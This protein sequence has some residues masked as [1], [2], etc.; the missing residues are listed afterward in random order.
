MRVLLLAPFPPRCDATHGGARVLGQ[1]ISHL[2][3]R[4]QVAVIYLRENGEPGIDPDVKARCDRVWE[5]ALPVHPTRGI[6]HWARR[7]SVL[8]GLLRGY[9]EWAL[10]WRVT[11]FQEQLQIA[12]QTWNPDVIQVEYSVM[13]QYLQGLDG[14]GIPSILTIYEPVAHAAAE[15]ALRPRHLAIQLLLLQ[16]AW[17]RYERRIIAAASAVVTF[18]DRD[19]KLIEKLAPDARVACIPLG[20]DLT[21]QPLDPLGTTPTSIT[22]IGNFSHPPNVD[23]AE[24]LIQSIFPAVQ[25]QVPDAILCIVGDRVPNNIRQMATRSIVVTGWVPSVIPYLDHAAV[26]AAPIR[27]GG[28]MRVKMLEALIA[29]K[30]I[31]ASPRA[32]E[33]IGV[34]A[35][36]HLLL[37]HDDRQFADAITCLLRNDPLR[38]ELAHNARAWALSHLGWSQAMT[39]YEVLY[40]SL[41]QGIP[42]GEAIMAG[43][44]HSEPGIQA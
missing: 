6:S 15:R 27:T 2:A 16:L 12:I 22:F 5:V 9:P 32:V 39:R 26:M 41:T 3:D 1:V 31:V 7:L 29:G 33:G 10:N 8:Q 37:A 28:G 42:A 11:A 21:I 13:G 14:Y 20:S 38:L 34:Q 17:K 35:G 40:L 24:R 44:A 19:R 30:A 36:I 4:H 23:A 18:T 25:E 43:H